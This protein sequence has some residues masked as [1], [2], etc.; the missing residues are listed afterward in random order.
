MTE[1]SKPTV[2]PDDF[3]T[4]YRDWEVEALKVATENKARLFSV[5][6]AAGVTLVRVAFN[7]EGDSGGIEH[8]AAF[9]GEE[10]IELPK[11]PVEIASLRYSD[12][13]PYRREL[14]TS[15]AI[16]TVVY[17]LL[18]AT[19]GGWENNDGAFGE[20]VFD[21]AKESIVLDFN[22]RITDSENTT[23]TW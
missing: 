18:S 15:E 12:S 13:E 10:P 6:A 22:E 2:T 17:D 7:G 8:V 20:F 14:P 5:L 19:N 4:R 9:K 21:V 3:W 16:D 23:Y 11:A 1:I